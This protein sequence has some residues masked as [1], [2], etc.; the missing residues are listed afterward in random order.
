MGLVR[1]LRGI[2]FA[3]NA[4]TSFMMLFDWMYPGAFTGLFFDVAFIGW[5][6]ERSLSPGPQISHLYAH[7]ATS[8]RAVVP[9]PSLHHARPQTHG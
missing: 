5:L 2:A 7:P 3:F 1:D 8:H 6:P 9:R 4:K